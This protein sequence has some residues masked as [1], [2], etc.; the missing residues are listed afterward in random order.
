[1]HSGQGSQYG[2]DNWQ[3]FC[4]A[5]NL[6][7]RMS[8]RGNC[9]DNAVAESFFS[10]LKKKSTSENGSTKPVIWPALISLITLKRS[11]TGSAATATLVAS[12]RRPSNRPR[13]ED[14]I[15]LPSWGQSKNNT[16]IWRCYDS[17][18]CSRIIQNRSH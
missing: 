10:W 18:A 9:R 6:A 13:R 4:R 5:N 2:S 14:R 8:Q 15:C 16:T 17:S 1:M 3:C 11:I 12:V 7:P